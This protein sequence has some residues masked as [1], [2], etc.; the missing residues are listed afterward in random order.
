MDVLSW[1]LAILALLGLGALLS[2]W[3]WIW[4]WIAGPAVRHLGKCWGQGL[5]RGM[6]NPEETTGP[7]ATMQKVGILPPQVLPERTAPAPA[8]DRTPTDPDVHAQ[9]TIT[10]KRIR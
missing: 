7:V 1:P 8:G 10:G 5:A 3:F 2:I 9:Y 6:R 4:A